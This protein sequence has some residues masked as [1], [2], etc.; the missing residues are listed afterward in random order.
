[1]SAEVTEIPSYFK[2]DHVRVFQKPEKNPDDYTDTDK[3]IVTFLQGNK[4]AGKS[5][6]LERIGERHKLA[7][8]T[9]VDLLAVDNYENLYPMINNN[10]AK[11]Y[12]D[13]KDMNPEDDEPPP[14]L[15]DTRYKILVIIPDYVEIKEENRDIANGKL[16][17]IRNKREIVNYGLN[18]WKPNAD[19][20]MIIPNPNWD[21]IEWIKFKKLPIPT[22]GFKNRD[23]FVAKL[24]E[25][26]FIGRDEGRYICLNPVFFSDKNHKFRLLEQ[27]LREIGLIV[28]THFKPTTP[29][30]AGRLRGT[31]I[32]VPFEEMTQQERNRHRVTILMRELGSVAPAGLKGEPLETLVKKAI[33]N[34]IRI[35]RHYRMSLICD[36]QRHADV[37][38]SIRDQRDYFIWKQTNSDM[39]PEDYKWLKDEIRKKREEVIAS[40]DD[41][42]GDKLAN[43][44][45]PDIE[46]LKKDEA[47]VLYPTKNKFGRRW[48]KL[49]IRPA[50]FH[51]HQEDDDFEQ[52]T[53]LGFGTGWFFT[54]KGEDGK[55]VETIQQQNAEDKDVLSAEQDKV[56]SLVSAWT[57]K[58]LPPDKRMSLDKAFEKLTEMNLCSWK[59]AAGLRKFMSR[60][61]GGKTP[62]SGKN[63]TTESNSEE[64]E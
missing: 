22:K 52:Q 42:R 12:A 57:D 33:L 4:G 54:T 45:Y 50:H 13:Y 15:C 7:G 21:G 35:V 26:L 37:I 23:S 58:N 6:L 28:R 14:C 40:F 53:S 9:V 27:I 41:G 60:K 56:F 8:H 2:Y 34:V 29:E 19:G 59:N 47:I 49:R 39:F 63:G 44:H 48:K 10:C 30:E 38:P 36:F 64:S 17:A 1:M 18:E 3:A 61:K 51:H 46:N 32:P 11:Y 55:L 43:L 16:L 24:T 62:K 25:I 31:N 20:V 5:S